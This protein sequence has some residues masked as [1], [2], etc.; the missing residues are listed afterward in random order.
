VIELGRVGIRSGM[1]QVDDAGA[2]VDAAREV[3]ELG[4]GAFWIPARNVFERAA[5]LLPATRRLVVA[6]SVVSI[7]TDD[8][9]EV[10]AGHARL[11]DA[12]PGRFLLGLG[13]SHRPLVERDT[14]RRY[15]RPVEAMASYLDE[16]D[17]AP[18][19]VPA[20]ERIVA[21][22]WPRMLELAR[23]RALGSHPYLVTPE[24]TRD[25]R[26]RLGP[27]PVLAP[28]Q[29]VVLET[30]PARAREIGRDHLAN[31]YLSLPNYA[32]NFVRLGFSE[33]DVAGSCSD[34]LVDGI[35]GWGDIAAVQG[36]IQ[37]HLD[38]GASH[39]AVQAVNGD[40]TAFPRAEWR[41]LAAALVP[42]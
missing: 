42:A 22:I 32:R 6:S 7:W 9:A 27:G 33:E 15:E 5:A 13:V 10:A 4:F 28:G 1:V 31:P 36:R 41:E 20:D 3:E 35:V 30:D 40:R 23:D 11:A 21:A 14:T 2:W 17:A 25:A 26:E 39:V 16:L 29:V 8:A 38:A 24:H 18:R 12:Y 19:P 34:R 37:E